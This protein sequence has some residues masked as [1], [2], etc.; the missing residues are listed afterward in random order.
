MYGVCRSKNPSIHHANDDVFRMCKLSIIRA[1]YF[2]W[3]W[4]RCAQKTSARNIFVVV[5]VEMGLCGE[6]WLNVKSLIS[7]YSWIMHVVAVVF[8]SPNNRIESTIIQLYEWRTHTHNSIEN[9]QI[10]YTFSFPFHAK[11]RF[12]SII[13][14]QLHQFE[15]M[16]IQFERT[17]R[18]FFFSSFMMNTFLSTVYWHSFYLPFSIWMLDEIFFRSI[19]FAFNR[20]WTVNG[21]ISSY[22]IALFLP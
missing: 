7:I 17:A 22:Y 20:L 2:L 14:I 4:Q 8:V 5:V 21:L 3:N 13:S 12:F 10:E 11:R 18:F 19:C 6:T 16:L 9:L 15:V 1:Y